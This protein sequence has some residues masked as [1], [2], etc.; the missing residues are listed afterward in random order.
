MIRNEKGFTAIEL[1][2]AIAVAAVLGGT[3]TMTALQ[4]TNGAGNS[5][6]TMAVAAETQ[7]AGY[8]I[9]RD[10]LAAESIV[11][12]GLTAPTFLV[13]TWTEQDYAGGGS[14]VYH[15]TTYSFQN[16]AGG[17]G[18]LFRNH[19]SSAGADDDAIVARYLR[20]DPGNPGVSSNAS[21]VDPVLSVTL[22]AASG[23]V[24]QARTY[25]YNR[26]TDFAR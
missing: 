1:L 24:S 25:V 7:R 3:A 23:D 5:Q 6:A 10:V 21:Y 9:G 22:R 12:D 11:T 4:I 15:S 20:F 19:W 17:V 16:L 18:E 13:L 2:V 26:R 14:A 8:A